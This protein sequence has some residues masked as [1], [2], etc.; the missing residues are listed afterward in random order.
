MTNEEIRGA[1][2]PSDYKMDF[3]S[4]IESILVMADTLRCLTFVSTAQ[5]LELIAGM[6]LEY[7]RNVHLNG[8]PYKPYADNLNEFKARGGKWQ[9]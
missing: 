9:D 2:L 1:S 5:K 3:N 8:I 6:A 4:T 7:M